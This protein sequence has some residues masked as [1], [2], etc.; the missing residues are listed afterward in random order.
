MNLK[1]V[2]RAIER[3]AAGQPAV[4]SI[5]RNDI[6]RLNAAPSVKYGVF[7]WLQG[8]HRTSLDSSLMEWN[9]TFFYADR[10]TENKGNEIEVQSVGVETLENIL[11]TL[12]D[13][14]VYAGEHAFNTF[15]QRF[16]DECAGV[17]C[18]V[19]LAVPKDG[20]CSKEYEFLVNDGE[21]NL[22]FNEDYKV[23]VWH[24]EERD[25]FII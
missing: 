20:V 22:D 10:L 4:G 7:A 14:G 17:W 9:F 6:F 3:V 8:E 25:I 18:S 2:I 21:Y 24:T 12:E 23:W 19:S 11:R 13:L 1:Q 16:S 5:V 15:N